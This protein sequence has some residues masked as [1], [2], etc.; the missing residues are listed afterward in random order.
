[1]LKQ[2]SR[3]QVTTFLLV[4]TVFLL[5]SCSNQKPDASQ[6]AAPTGVPV[7]VAAVTTSTIA[8]TSDYVATLVSRSSVTLQPQ[9]EGRVSQILVKAGAKVKAGT[10]LMRVDAQKQ[11]ASVNSTVAAIQ[12][13]QASL[14]N[15]RQTLRSL[16]ATREAKLSTLNFQKQDF[17][18]YSSLLAEGAV[19]KQTLAQSRNLLNAAQ[20][21]L[22]SVNAQIQAQQALVRRAQE[23][24]LQAQADSQQQQV[25]LQYYK[26]AAPFTGIIGD[27]PVKVG[28]QVTTASQLLTLTQ[29]DVLEVNI[30]VPT[31]KAGQ[32]RQGLPVELLDPTGKVIGTSTVFFISPKV[33]DQSQSVLVKAR[34]DNRAGRLRA[35]QV[36]QARLVWQRRSGVLVPT[37][38]VSRVAGLDFVFVAQP[39]KE[40]ATLIAHQRP[41]QLGEIQGNTYQV[42]SGLKPSEKVVVSGILKL[43]DGAPITVTQ[44]S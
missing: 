25:A 12:Q 1:M 35:D 40:P 41:V 15:V 21:D 14:E 32:V 19:S 36:I 29:N 3:K 2:L 5:G 27:I 22:E 30:A 43:A 8:D 4:S 44:G 16:N 10:I 18:R 31:E 20:A 7:T 42:I 23:A 11:Q 33:N 6:A 17:I 9:I 38:A 37:S 24:L 28:D 26:V 34:Y 39:G 13:S